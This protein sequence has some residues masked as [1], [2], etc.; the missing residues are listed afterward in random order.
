MGASPQ[1]L[2]PKL[3]NTVMKEKC[4]IYTP[5]PR[6]SDKV[7]AAAV[8]ENALLSYSRISL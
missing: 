8:C 4:Y 6:L 3:L 1:V 7:K 5:A 2:H